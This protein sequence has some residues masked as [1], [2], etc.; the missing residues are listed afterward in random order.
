[1]GITFVE[2]MFQLMEEAP[3]TTAQEKDAFES[4]RWAYTLG[5]PLEQNPHYKFNHDALFWHRGWVKQAQD[6]FRG[7]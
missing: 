4:G 1:M 7:Y 3:L 5:V 2:W 6:D